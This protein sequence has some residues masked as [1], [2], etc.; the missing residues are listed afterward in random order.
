MFSLDLF[1]CFNV[2]GPEFVRRNFNDRFAG[3]EQIKILLQ[4]LEPSSSGL[5]ATNPRQ[6][7]AFNVV[8]DPKYFS[9]SR[10]SEKLDQAEEIS[11]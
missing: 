11:R 9:T 6:F 2:C 5:V 10:S 7:N 8:S 3:I 1:K 4:I